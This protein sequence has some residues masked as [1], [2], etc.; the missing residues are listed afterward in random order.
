MDNRCFD[1]QDCENLKEWVAV[2]MG[3]DKA[4]GWRITMDEKNHRL[5]FYWSRPD[6]GDDYFPL[7]VQCDADVI[8]PIIE[9]FLVIAKYGDEPDHDGHNK[10]GFR[11]YNEAWGHVDGSSRAFMAVA[12]CWAMFGK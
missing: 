2:C 3:N 9:R 6:A 5:V 12:P 10:R 1:V 7:P 11:I 4:V 8:T